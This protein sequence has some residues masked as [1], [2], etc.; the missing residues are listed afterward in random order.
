M[1]QQM[2]DY[3]INDAVDDFQDTID[4]VKELARIFKDEKLEHIVRELGEYKTYVGNLKRKMPEKP[5]GYAIYYFAGIDYYPL[6]GTF[7]NVHP[8]YTNLVRAEQVAQ[9]FS[10][11]EPDVEFG[12]YPVNSDLDIIG[13]SVKKYGEFRGPIRSLKESVQK[14]FFR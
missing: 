13:K 2:L 8:I 1:D 7:L 9:E 14:S 11:R 12:I 3:I 6:S 4:G 10:A 5:A